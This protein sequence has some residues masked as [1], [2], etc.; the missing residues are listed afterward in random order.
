M[1]HLGLILHYRYLI[2]IPLLLIEGPITIFVSAFLASQ[3][4]FE[5]EDIILLAV[6]SNVVG[7][8]T[9]YALGRFGGKFLTRLRG[10]ILHL[11]DAR[12][13]KMQSYFKRHGGKTLVLGKISLMFGGPA[14]VTAGITKYSP[15][16]FVFF[17]LLGD[18]PM[19]FILFGLGF[20]FGSAIGNFGHYIRDYGLIILVV[21]AVSYLIYRFTR[22][23]LDTNQ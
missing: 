13:A 11:D 15:L 22:R 21:A 17:N 14:L 2:L 9:H 12:L 4:Y 8:F 3:K 23:E 6:M 10:P 19:T 16:K 7:D 5:P 20:Y 1:N 18:I